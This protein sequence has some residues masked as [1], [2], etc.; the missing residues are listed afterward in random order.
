MTPFLIVLAGMALAVLLLAG[1]RQLIDMHEDDSIHLGEQ[2]GGVIKDQLTLARKVGSIDHWAKL[3]TLATV[4]YG[5][6]LGGYFIYQ[7]WV[8]S[9]RLPGS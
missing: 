5:L 7:Q 2:Q 3:L 8:E 1:W 4:A 6:A 9:G